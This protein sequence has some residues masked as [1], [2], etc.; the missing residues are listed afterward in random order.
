MQYYDSLYIVKKFIPQETILINEG[1][2]TMDVGRT[3]FGHE[4]PKKRLDAGTLGTMGV[5]I[6]FCVA[7]RLVHPKTPVVGILGDSAFGFSAMEIES[8][9][10]HN[11]NFVCIII[12]NSGIY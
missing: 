8:A 7:A 10:R 11:L 2:N 12:N 4:N 1:F 3:V 5:G 9:I 6:P